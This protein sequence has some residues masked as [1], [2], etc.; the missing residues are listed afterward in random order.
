MAFDLSD[1]ET[2]E[3]R[4]IR[5]WADHPNGSIVTSM[6]SYDGDSCVF[7]AE[8]RFDKFDTAITASGYAHEVQGSSQVNKTSFIENAETS[9]IGRGLANCSYSTHGKRPS[10]TEM[11]K[12]A[13]YEP[14]VTESIN[15]RG[16]VTVRTQ[17]PKIQVLSTSLA[18]S[19]QKGFI[20][21]LAKT[22]GLDGNDLLEALRA[23]CDDPALEI[24][25]I[26]IPQASAIINAWK[27]SQ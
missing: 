13:R 4:L 18:S 23:I 27:G 5:F 15:D 12:V 3:D 10:R 7:R 20:R 24:D 17:Y 26:T 8:V 9:A 22:R 25:N 14:T 6:M 11:E 21:V 2:V 19:K 1:Y 16:D